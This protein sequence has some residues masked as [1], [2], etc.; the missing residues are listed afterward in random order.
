MMPQ[1]PISWEQ[2]IVQTRMIAEQRLSLPD[3]G[4]GQ[5]INTRERRTATEVNAIGGMMERRVICVRGY[6]VSRWRN[7]ID[8]RIRCICSMRRKT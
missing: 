1:P 3:F 8:K 6:S 7:C 5:M 2:E 4:V